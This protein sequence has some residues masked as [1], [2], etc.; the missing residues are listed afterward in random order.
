[1][2]FKLDDFGSPFDGWVFLLIHSPLPSYFLANSID[3][4]YDCPLARIDDMELPDGGT[5]TLFHYH[6]AVRHLKYFLAEAPKQN[7]GWQWE[8]KLLIIKGDSASN[9]ADTI[10][11]DFTSSSADDPLDLIGIQRSQLIDQLLQ[12][13][14]VVSLLDLDMDDTTSLP[15]KM[16]KQR[17]AL[18][19]SCNDIIDYIEQHQLDLSD[20]EQM[21]AKEKLFSP[22]E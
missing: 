13:F 4:L 16:R 12:S 1:M 19:Q 10:L 17:L 8:D 2:K 3:Q 18:Q 14:T 11:A 20:D 22:Y 21:T 15:A 5:W 6:D 7:T 9:I